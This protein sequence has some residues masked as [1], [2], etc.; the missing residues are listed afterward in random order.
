M[1]NKNLES[2]QIT[3][4][5]CG[6]D[7]ELRAQRLEADLATTK[8]RSAEIEKELISR[9]NQLINDVATAEQRA[10]T[11]GQSSPEFQ[12]LLTQFRDER[13]IAAS[14]QKYFEQAAEKSKEKQDQDSDTILSLKIDRSDLMRLNYRLLKQA[15]QA[16]SELEEYTQQN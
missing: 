13:E 7:N 16:E 1:S 5:H 11:A 6:C 9:I 8:A 4:T 15:E 3:P 12:A 10:S 14:R 2:E